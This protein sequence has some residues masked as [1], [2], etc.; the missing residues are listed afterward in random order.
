[1]QALLQATIR[2][3]PKPFL[4]GLQQLHNWGTEGRA[5]VVSR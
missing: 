1:M 3:T 2:L 5:T 4:Q